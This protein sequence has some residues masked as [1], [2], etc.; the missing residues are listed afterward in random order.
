MRICL[1]ATIR[2]IVAAGLLPVLACASTP[3]GP[4]PSSAGI[5]PLSQVHRGLHGVAYTVFEGTQPEAMDVEIL[6]VLNN[7]LG[8][9]K[10]MI[11]ARLRGAK[12]EYTGVV[13]GMSGSP[14]Y[15]DG[16]LL[17]ALAYRIGEFSKEPIAGITPIAQ[18][19]EVR[20]G[21]T[22]LALNPRAEA[23][24]GSQ[25]AQVD[26]APGLPGLHAPAIV[27]IET[28]LV[29]AGF[30]QEAARLWQERFSGTSLAPV[31]TLGGSSS[32]QP[33]PEPL[34]P[35]SAVSAVLVRGDLEIAATCTV[36]YLDA[37]QL[38]ACGHPITQFG[39]V[40][41]PMTKAE[42]LATVPS[43]LNAFKIVNT[44][45]TVGALTEDLYS[46]VR[47][48]FGTKARMIPVTVR[49][50]GAARPQT[51][52]FEVIDQRQVTPTAM[53][54]SVFQSLMD[55]NSLGA[56]TS[57]HLTGT[58]SVEDY[59]PL[60][61]EGWAAPSDSTASNLSAALMVGERFTRLYN[62]AA[63][64]AQVQSVDLTFE[65][66]PGRRTLQLE[67]ARSSAIEVHA[68]ETITLEAAV[69]PYRGEIRN[70]RIPVTLPAS[71]PSGPIRLLVSDGATLDRLTQASPA[72]PGSKSLDLNATMAQIAGLHRNDRLYVTLL[73]PAAQAVLDGRTLLEL[74]VSMANI[75]E[76]LRGSQELILSGESTIPVTSIPV[77]A[78]LAGQQ[79]VSLRIL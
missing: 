36:T 33:Q 77:E 18:M 13:A 75:Y 4:P 63:T 35:G 28:P 29:M 10:D 30:S 76:P 62:N 11:L 31:S 71:L 19:L 47:G 70:I 44:T 15:V 17:G 74:P 78:V 69:R 37:N 67:A 48:T 53:L 60:K 2:S 41:I 16:K 55:S 39:P 58:M 26:A 7:A 43:P 79:V 65:A 14:V 9:G 57:L 27:P 59:T 22:G 24:A 12:P 64:R 50:T 49:L 25:T 6:G 54:V 73:T 51:M 32:A 46:G 34:V 68:G 61:L 56:D 8:P 1:K 66:V 40:S 45:E 38:L 5:F 52:H 21:A 42:V 72:R 23:A 3:G 20:D